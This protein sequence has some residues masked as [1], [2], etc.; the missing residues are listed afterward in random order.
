VTIPEKS[1]S[2]PREFLGSLIPII[3]WLPSYKL[4]GL[5]GDV[6]AGL[7]LWAM[8]VPQA[9]AY[10]GIAGV[11]P[12]YGLYAVPL[13]MLAYAAFGTSRTLAAGPESAIAIISAVTVAG[14]VAQDPSKFLALT[15]LLALIVGVLFLLFGLLRLGWV[16]NFLAQPVLQGF[17]QGIALI[18]II[19]QL[20]TLFGTEAA[21][22]QLLKS[23][24]NLPQLIGLEND[25]AG[26]IVWSWAV[27]ATL[28]EANLL[29]A[30]VGLSSLALLF[31]LRRF[32]P[33]APSA[34]IAVVLTI[35]AV[36]LFS[37]SDHGVRVIGE[38]ETGM[39]ALALPALSLQ[40]VVA[41][42]PGALAIVLLGYAVSLS[43]AK[44]GAQETGEEIDS[45]QEL[46]AL[47]MANLGAA[48]SSGF[49]VCG[50]LSR[51]V[52][53]RRAHG[54]SQVVSM[55]NAGLIV[56]TLLFALP[57]FFMLP[58]AALS[59]IVIQAMLGLLDF[60]YFRRLLRFSRAEFAYAMVALLGV[61]F[62][63]ILH[64]VTLG[65][66]LALAVLIQRVSRPATAALGR[67]PGTNTF[68]EI[69]SW[70]GAEA[71]PGLL[72]FRFDAPIIFPNAGYFAD[73]VRR[74]IAEAATPV[75]QVLIPAQQI[76]QLDST[77]ADQLARL[78]T[79][80]EEQRIELSVAEAKSALH[81]AM[82]RTGLEDK[83][84]A[85]HFYDSVEEGVEAF[86]QAQERRV[87]LSG[88]K[89]QR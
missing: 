59:A 89:A 82:R 4:A 1:R 41:L 75:R 15:A 60:A 67:L 49:V 48:F 56:L 16:A 65:V 80:L 46:V 30:A 33:T 26:F 54:K 43:V 53:V 9:L 27:L 36:H 10:A 37:L 38:V 2:N 72:I 24:D 5:R 47:G 71:L 11:P 62:L 84:G 17:V 58:K 79:E 29:T 57:L 68:R 14:L 8:T 63:G 74:L 12:V 44:V 3:T 78:Q 81:E 40:D 70:P 45:N 51:G 21:T 64:G 50:S 19:G 7:A 83:I 76:N 22:A 87:G 77:G 28:G 23:T 69:S 34:L 31:A 85:D 52:V 86:L 18:V 35:L 39:I 13:A 61:L 25:Y 32:R 73:E 6:L 55:V 66:V 88:E 42:L 20:P